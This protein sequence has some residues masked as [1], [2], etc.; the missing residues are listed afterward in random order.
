MRSSSIASDG[1]LVISTLVFVRYFASHVGLGSVYVQLGD[2]DG[3]VREHE[4]LTRIA[5]SLQ[6]AMHEKGLDSFPN[7]ASVYA[8]RLLKQSVVLTEQ[9]IELMKVEPADSSR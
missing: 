2:K 5:L 7:M 9:R 1:C 4:A 6:K 8:D 3:A